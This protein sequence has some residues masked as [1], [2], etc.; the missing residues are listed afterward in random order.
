MKQTLLE[1]LR[2]YDKS[3]LPF[4]MPG[5]KRNTSLSGEEGYLSVLRADC[6]ITEIEGFDNLAAPSGILMELQQ[7]T[8]SLF[9]SEETKLLV[10]GSTVGILS[11]IFAAVQDGGEVLAARNCHQ[12]VLHGLMLVNATV[13]YLQPD[14]DEETGIVGAVTVEMVEKALKEGKKP[15]LLILTSPTYEGIVSDV[16]GICD[17]AHR[18]G[19]P[20]LVDS[21]HGAHFSFG[22]FPESAVLCG[23]DL[24]VQ[25]LHKTLPSLTQT[26]L[27]HRN[28]TLISP[29]RICAA[30]NIFQTSSPS[31]L[32]LASIDG[33]VDLLIKDG[34]RIFE[35]WE[36]ALDHFYCSTKKM[37]KL[38]VLKKD[39]RHSV[40]S[41]A[42]LFDKSKLI[43]STV[44]T[45]KTGVYLAD[46]LR[47]EYKIEVEMAAKHYLIAMTGPGDTIKTL[48][49]LANALIE[50]DERFEIEER[51][52]EQCEPF[53]S[54]SFSAPP[55]IGRKIVSFR[56]ASEAKRIEVFLMESIGHTAA[57][58]VFVYPP[59]IPLF[60][61]GE[62]ITS[63]A[64]SYL[65]SEKEAG[66]HVYRSEGNNTDRIYVLDGNRSHSSQ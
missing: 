39:N 12:S 35:E 26:A 4:H 55:A 21:A 30:I 1:T 19:V 2:E 62:E 41:K 22:H 64:V 24:V 63:E 37:K 42:F 29:E 60:V 13:S 51:T 14:I 61:P 15:Q 52:K 8:A 46:L 48:Q 5:H 11:A 58:A 59:G 57:E 32:L 23:A 38:S 47:N 44:G 45:G 49:F 18:Y 3:M 66:C 16:R 7:K 65:I 31:Y 20:V 10:N 34:I 50:I 36:D 43:I 33:C 6:D 17:A 53:P 54:D 28:G 25:S 9:H 27:L 40:F 56:E